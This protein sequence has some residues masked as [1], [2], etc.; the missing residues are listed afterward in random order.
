M[1]KIVSVLACMVMV[2][3]GGVTLAACGGT[4][5]PGMITPVTETVTLGSV[6]F[7]NSDTFKIAMGKENNFVASGDASKFT[8]EQV[9]AFGS[10]H[11][12]VGQGYIVVRVNANVGDT[13][14]FA[15]VTEEKADEKLGDVVP[16]VIKQVTVTEDGDENT[17]I[18]NVSTG[19]EKGFWRVEVKTSQDTEST[20]YVLNVKGVTLPTA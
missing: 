16:N 19:K 4:P 6:D 12:S 15:F 17:F 5:A 20:A 18:L 2:L 3:V 8:A 1:K 14:K 9:A 10:N 11:S 13:M 7:R